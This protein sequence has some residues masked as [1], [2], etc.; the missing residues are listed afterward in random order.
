[1]PSQPSTYENANIDILDSICR[2]KRRKTQKR[3]MRYLL[4][5]YPMGPRPEVPSKSAILPAKT[6]FKHS[7]DGKEVN[8]IA[9][10]MLPDHKPPFGKD[11]WRR[12]KCEIEDRI[13]EA[14]SAAIADAFSEM[15]K[16]R[17]S[18]T[19]EAMLQ[20]TERSVQLVRLRPT[21]FSE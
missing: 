1:M 14:I 10:A 13:Q 15:H 7:P 6:R 11:A 8:K 4:D 16:F 9:E 5:Q 12:L 2:K 20:V 18:E 21:K 3:V 19:Q 17:F